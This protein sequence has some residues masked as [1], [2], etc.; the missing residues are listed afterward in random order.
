MD[1]AEIYT[2]TVKRRSGDTVLRWRR[3]DRSVYIRLLFGSAD[4]EICAPDDRCYSEKL[5]AIRHIVFDMLL[6]NGCVLVVL[7]WGV[8]IRLYL[9]ANIAIESRFLIIRIAFVYYIAIG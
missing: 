1:D 9:V 5:I 4:M 7:C 8:S 6:K 3:Y 2:T